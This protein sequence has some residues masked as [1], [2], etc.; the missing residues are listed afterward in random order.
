MKG[1]LN[2]RVSL[3][4]AILLGLTDGAMDAKP[5]TIYLLT[6][7]NGK[8]LSNC[9]FCSQARSSG[10]RADM[11]SRVIWPMFLSEEVI[12]RLKASARKRLIKRVCI[13]TINYPNLFKEVLGLVF[14]IRAEVNIPISVSCQP[15][16]SEQ[17]KKLKATGIDRLSIP[18]D[19]ASEILFEKVK[20]SSV[21]GP[22]IWNKHIEVLKSAVQIFGKGNVSTHLIVGLGETDEDLLNMVQKMVVM[23]VYPAIFAFTPIPGTKLEAKT[24]PK[25]ERYRRIQLAH[26]LITEGKASFRDVIFDYEGYIKGFYLDE[27]LLKETIKMGVPFMTSGCPGCNR[28]FFNERVGG[29]LY[30]YPRPLNKIEIEKIENLILGSI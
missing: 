14:K 1:P 28:P 21:K 6:Y 15:L 16:T 19:A 8:C 24:Q 25:I 27:D 30:N 5:T 9:G 13:Q 29:T 2:V 22:F 7:H 17:M 18:L 11:L 23:G 4:S 26:Y 20:G 10:T 3:G 12:S